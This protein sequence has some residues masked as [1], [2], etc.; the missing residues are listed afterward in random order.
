MHDLRPGLVRPVRLDPLG[1]SGPTRWQARTRAWRRTSRGFYVPA[2]VDAADVEQRI[3]EAS[4]VVPRGMGITGWAAAR[5]QGARWFSGTGTAAAPLP[6]TILISTFD[7]RPQ[8]G[9]ELS[10]EGTSPDRIIDVDGVR[11]TDPAWT[12]AFLMRRAVSLVQ[13]VV[14]LD[15]AAYDDL[16]SLAEVASIIAGQRSWTGV[17]QAR[18]ALALASENSWSPQETVMRLAWTD[19]TGLPAPLA[20]RPLFDLTGRHLGTPD[21][22]DPRAGVVGEYDGAVHLARERRLADVR[23]EERYRQHGLEVVRW[24]AGDPVDSFRARLLAAYRRTEARMTPLACTVVPPP[25]WTPTTTV[26]RRRSL[27]G[28]QRARFLRYRAA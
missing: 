17:P 9:I 12:T 20:N 27:T 10:G 19:G 24:L 28:D 6:V 2:S 26:A 8:P 14:A 15:M 7:I 11:V 16:V 18:A 22:L 5:W 25:W 4:V 23:A 3:L 1:L 13:A 21:L